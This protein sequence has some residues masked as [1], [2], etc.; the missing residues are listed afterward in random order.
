MAEWDVVSR[1]STSADPWVV[2]SRTPADR[3]KAGAPLGVRAAVGSVPAQAKLQALRKFFPDAEP[4]GDGNF[5]YTDPK[6]GQPTVYN[7]PGLDVGDIASLPAEA[8]EIVGSGIGGALGAA[9]GSPGGPVG[10][11]AGAAGGSGVGGTVGR[12]AVQRGTMAALGVSDPRSAQEQAAEAA[13]TAGL[14]ALGPVIL[15]AG[16][17]AIAGGARLL[18]RGGAAGRTAVQQAVDDMTRFGASPTVAQATQSGVQDSIESI[19]AK[20]PGGAGVIRRAAKDTSETVGNAVRQKTA[21]LAAS[22]EL[23]PEIAGRAIQ[24]GI[25]GFT[26]QV[27]SRAESMFGRVNEYF[28]PVVASDGTEQAATVS[29]SN[30]QDMLKALSA[31]VKGAPNVGAAIGNPT[32]KKLSDAL[33]TDAAGGTLAYDSLAAMRS[34][35][36]RRLGTPS[37]VDDIPRGELKRLYGAITADMRAAAEAKGPDALKAFDR[38]NKFYSAAL[39]RIDD[40]LDPLIANKTPEQIFKHIESGTRDGASK[41]RTLYRSL[42][43][44]QRRVVTA[45]VMSRLGKGTPGAQSAEGDV[46]SFNTFLTNWNRMNDTAKDVLFSGLSDGSAM[47]A[48]MNALARA[49]ARMRESSRAFSNPSG[50]ATGLA[51]VA[52]TAGGVAA[53]MATGDFTWPLA[54]AMT[55]VGANIS[56]RLLTNKRFV[57]WLADSTQVRPE[58]AGAYIGRLGAVAANSSAQDAA[59]I[60]EYMDVLATEGE[61]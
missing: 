22:E 35:I 53:G 45:T 37:L 24:S 39:T 11:L 18:T 8:A 46:F 55:G 31:P 30:T 10:M 20:Y 9:A 28:K 5:I 44:E 52:M 33:A 54:M 21:A 23:E 6:T 34:A 47:K 17:A 15:P 41:A 59:A 16:R 12:E 49:A 60:Q 48:D 42:S 2:T 3:F 57:R 27:M 43:M 25:S 1:A 51:G 4:I 26:G 13:T 50:T 40:V 19:L 14:N 56:A 61:R 7:R 32:I 29:V 38:A 36:G 58:G